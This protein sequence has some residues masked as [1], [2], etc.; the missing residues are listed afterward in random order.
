MK[1]SRPR[2]KVSSQLKVLI[3]Q[4]ELLQKEIDELKTDIDNRKKEKDEILKNLEPIIE[5]KK[6]DYKIE[7]D[8]LRASK[9]K[10]KDKFHADQDAYYKQQQLI[11]DIEWKTKIKNRLIREEARKKR[12]AEEKLAEEEEKKNVEKFNPGQI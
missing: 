2:K 7:I 11:Q 4:R 3:D 6:E 8:E 12:E 1:R 10:I 5:S 9:Q